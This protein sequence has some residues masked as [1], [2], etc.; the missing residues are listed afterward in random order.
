MVDTD[1]TGEYP[2]SGYFLSGKKMLSMNYDSKEMKENPYVYK[3][4]YR[5]I[6]LKT[7]FRV[8]LFKLWKQGDKA[9]LD[10]L[11]EDRGFGREKTGR[12]FYDQLILGF[13]NGGY[14]LNKKD[15]YLAL[16]GEPE[17]NPLIQSGK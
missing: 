17:D 6:T 4:D 1:L 10:R 15:E 12:L 14:P 3:T 5:S 13:H 8:E 2:S 16:D 11:L 9:G 7:A